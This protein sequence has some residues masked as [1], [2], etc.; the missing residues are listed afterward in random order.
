[1]NAMT[2][3]SRHRIRNLGPGSLKPGT[4]YVSVTEISTILYHDEWVLH[5]GLCPHYC[6]DKQIFYFII[7]K[8]G[9]T[10]SII[11]KPNPD[12]GILFVSSLSYDN[13][14]K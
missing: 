13:G 10:R 12:I 1:M 2:L 9:N 11:Y 7:F 3:P 4:L 6:V 5:L 14:F 8:V